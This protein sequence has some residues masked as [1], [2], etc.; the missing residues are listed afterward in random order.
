MNIPLIYLDQ[1]VIRYLMRGELCLSKENSELHYVYSNQH[2]VELDSM[3]A[4]S[5]M[6]FLATLEKIDAR[7]IEL[8][9]DEHF[10]ILDSCVVHSTGSPQDF[11]AQFQE[12]RSEVNFDIN[13]LNAPLAWLNGNRDT[14]ALMDHPGQLLSGLQTML[15]EHG[16]Q[17]EDIP[18][19]EGFKASLEE[20]IKQMASI[21]EPIEKLRYRLGSEHGFS[22]CSKAENPLMEIW[23]K[24]KDLCPNITS[25]Q[26]FG[27]SPVIGNDPI[28]QYLG[29][30]GCCGVLDV[31]GFHAEKKSRKISKIP[32]IQSDAA[33]IAYGGFCSG[34]LS[35]D[36][37]LCVRAR[38][39]YTYRGVKTS[40][41]P[42]KVSV[43]PNESGKD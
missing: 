6:E 22:D 21:Q 7:F 39:I 28:P 15:G 2:F 17:I 27:F 20:N 26:F 31:I 1:N 14:K 12:S 24:I 9:M 23:D 18:G 32:N 25:D 30:V 10:R 5:R 38:A 19:G 4:N 40:V 3:D 36:N 29:V 41:L 13:V 8:Q 11:Y 16:L 43:V 42:I 33:H 35:G 37:R 34:I